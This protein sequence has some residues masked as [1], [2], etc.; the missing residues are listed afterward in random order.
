MILT[1]DQGLYDVS[2]QGTKDI[3]T[4]NIDGIAANGIR[5]NQFYANCTVCSPTRAAILTGTYPDYV[6][7][8]GVIRTKE[9]DNWGYLNPKVKLLPTYLKDAGYNTAIIGKWHLGLTLPNLP[10]EKG[11]DYFHGW[12]GDMMDDYWS[13]RRHDINYMR[14]NEKVIDPEGHATDL[15]SDWSIDYIKGQAKNKKPFFLYLAYNAPHFPVQPPVEWLEKV[16]M[17]EPQLPEKE[18]SWL[19]LLNTWT[20]ASERLFKL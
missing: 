2:Y 16:K 18:R 7:V 4:P 10:N 3:K 13:H 15:F 17:R 14:L 11:F 1:D 6:G 12:L 19:H 8:P 20:I 9:E 5:F